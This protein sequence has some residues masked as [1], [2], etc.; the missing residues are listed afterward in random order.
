MVLDIFARLDQADTET[1]AAKI[2]PHRLSK[3]SNNVIS[4]LGYLPSLPHVLGSLNSIDQ[5]PDLMEEVAQGMIVADRETGKYRL[6]LS[7]HPPLPIMGFGSRLQGRRDMPD[8]SNH[9]ACR[10]VEA[11]K[12]PNAFNTRSPTRLGVQQAMYAPERAGAVIKVP[13]HANVNREPP[14][15]RMATSPIPLA[16]GSLIVLTSPVIAQGLLLPTHLGP[17][18]GACPD[19]TLLGENSIEPTPSMD[20]QLALPT[21]AQQTDV[22]LKDHHSG[23]A[24]AFGHMTSLFGTT[25]SP[26]RLIIVIKTGDKLVRDDA[27][28]FLTDQLPLWRGMWHKSSLSIPTSSDSISEHFV[29]VSRSLAILNEGS[30]MGRIRLLLHRV[31]QYQ[32][33][34]RFLEEV[35]QRVMQPE[36]KRK[37]GIRDAAYAMNHLLAKLYI[38][39]WDLIGPAEKQRRRNLLHK[40]KHLGK[41]LVTLSSYMGFGIL[42]LGSP[43]AMGHM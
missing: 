12:D 33:Y 13:E 40:Q 24:Q 10:D 28:P 6:A 31:L 42:L 21:T 15:S 22:P 16:P 41:R 2:R 19:R 26:D 38:G 35:K 7:Q 17:A 30:V 29:K 11:N 3:M 37:R 23:F 9:H 4:Q 34:L 25:L 36:V 43:E 39:D 20:N 32:F 14:D 1:V 27:V 5:I 8:M 18:G